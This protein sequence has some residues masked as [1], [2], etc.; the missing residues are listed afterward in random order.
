MFSLPEISHDAVEA[1]RELRE[2]R[3]DKRRLDWLESLLAY[4]VHYSDVML[5]FDY[6]DGIWVSLHAKGLHG[7]MPVSARNVKTD[8]LRAAIDDAMAKPEQ[9]R[10]SGGAEV[11]NGE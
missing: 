11:A 2:L 10:A 6:E 4:E 1:A 3:A 5:Q 7:C 9:M 8:T